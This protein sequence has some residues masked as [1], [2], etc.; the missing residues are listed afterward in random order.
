VEIIANTGGGLLVQPD[1]HADLARALDELAR[2][3]LQLKELAQKAVE[4][5]RRTYTIDKMAK[6]TAEVYQFLVESSA[7]RVGHA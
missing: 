6:R 3:R 4:G 2:D 5:V 7:S 1:D